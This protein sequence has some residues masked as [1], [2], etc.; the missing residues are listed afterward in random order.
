MGTET[1]TDRLGSTA[2]GDIEFESGRVRRSLSSSAVVPR[3]AKIWPSADSILAWTRCG[4]WPI[5]RIACSAATRSEAAVLDPVTDAKIWAVDNSVCVLSSAYRVVSC[6]TAAPVRATTAAPT[7]ENTRT[8]S[9][10]L[11][12]RRGIEL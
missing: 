8:A 4:I 11:I 3:D 6:Q 9:F 2:D 1:W 12:E 7:A 5:A 10:R